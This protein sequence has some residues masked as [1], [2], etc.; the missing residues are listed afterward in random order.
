MKILQICNKSPYPPK[1]GGPIAMHALTQLLLKAG[2][3]VKILAINTP[4]Y[5]IS[6]DKI[7]TNF[8]ENTDIE[9]VFIDTN[10]NIKDATI[11]LLKNKS[12]HVARFYSPQMETKIIQTLQKEKYDFVLLET[13]YLSDYVDVIKKYSTAK[14]ILRSHNVEHLIWERIAKN[15]HFGLKKA[16][17]SLLAKQ[18][19]KYELQNIAK[20]DAIFCISEHDKCYFYQQN[21]NLHLFLIPFTVLPKIILYA[22]NQTDTPCNLFS[23]AS[24]DWQPNKEGLQWFIDKV[25]DKIHAAYPSLSLVIA[26]RNIPHWQ[27]VP[28]K[29]IIIVGEVENAEKFMQENGILIVPLWAGSGIRIK[30]IEAMSLSKVVITTSIGMQGIDAQHK[31]ELLI[32]NTADEFLSAVDFCINNPKEY[33]NI[34]QS[35]AQLI[36][37]HY[38]INV[39]IEKLNEVLSSIRV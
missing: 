31:K 24:M 20:Y 39:N 19:K 34:S 36:E 1:E 17:L 3:Q 6:Q 23:L 5:S 35:A 32:A 29:N 14:I 37:N 28:Q 15:Q 25:W 18:L 16:Y 33:K 21:A 11:A 7:D 9:T 2:H 10:L 38:S 27:S 22:E 30:I 4:K 26:G 8:K 13:I 12:Y